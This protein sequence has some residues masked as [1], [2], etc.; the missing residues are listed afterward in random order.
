M[1]RMQVCKSLVYNTIFIIHLTHCRQEAC[2]ST[3]RAP[4]R[5]SRP[6]ATPLTSCR[7]SIIICAVPYSTSSCTVFAGEHREM[8]LYLIRHAIAVDRSAPGI[9]DDRSRELTPQGIQKM[10]RSAAALA[11]VGVVIDEIWTSPLLRARQ[12]ADIVSQS[13]GVRGSPCIVRALSPGG[14]CEQLMR[15][16]AQH[17]DFSGVALIGHEPDLGKL[18]TFLLGGP[19]QSAVEFKKGGAA[20][21]EVDDFHPPVRGRLQWLLTP[22]QMK[23]MT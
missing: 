14:D 13:L 20:C 5:A 12:T 18:A 3:T 23:L 17:L 19:R 6:S 21:I 8:R 7:A 11:K 22:K 4:P 1:P 15:R 2:V 10:R 16:L 9:L